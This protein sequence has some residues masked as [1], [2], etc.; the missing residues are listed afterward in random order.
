MTAYSLRPMQPDDQAFS[1]QVYASTRQEEMALVNWPPEQKEAFLRMQFE[2]QTE[3]YRL[4]YPTAEYF[5]ILSGDRPVGRLLLERSPEQLLIM[6]ITIL[7][8]FRNSGTG[9]AI[10]RDLMDEASRSGVPLVLRVEFFNPAIRLYSRIGFVKTRDVNGVY[11]EMVWT[12]VA[13]PA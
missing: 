13:N 4:H 6:D 2:A 10:L 8:E 7:P 11:S 5:I 9:T 1:C 12:P 3:H